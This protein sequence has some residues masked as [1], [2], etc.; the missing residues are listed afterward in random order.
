MTARHCHAVQLPA[1]LTADGDAELQEG[2]GQ[3]TV[4][5][6]TEGWVSGHSFQISQSLKKKEKEKEKNFE[7]NKTKQQA[8]RPET[9]TATRMQGQGL[10]SH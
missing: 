4:R 2:H 1:V 7:G 8:H 6:T 9:D 5:K 10:T 3:P